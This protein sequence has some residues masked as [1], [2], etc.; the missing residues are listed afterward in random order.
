[1]NNTLKVQ[2]SPCQTGRWLVIEM[3][4]GSRAWGD[5]DSIF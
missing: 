1:M 2:I 4:H 3:Q 5:V